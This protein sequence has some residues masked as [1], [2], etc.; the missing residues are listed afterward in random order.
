MIGE[1][2]I[3]NIRESGNYLQGFFRS[4]I[5]LGVVGPQI[6]RH[7]LGEYGLIVLRFVKPDGE[8]LD[9]TGTLGLHEG[10]DQGGVYSPGEEGPLY[11]TVSMG[12]AEFKPTRMRSASQLI[13][14]ADKALYH[15]KEMGRNR[16]TV[17]K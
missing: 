14:E 15:S 11:V 7:P 1:G 8:G 13:A 3:I 16:V 4:Q 12:V 2:L 9:G 17:Q 6:L 5:Q 10:Y